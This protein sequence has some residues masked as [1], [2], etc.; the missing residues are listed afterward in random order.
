[1]QRERATGCLVATRRMIDLEDEFERRVLDHLVSARLAAP[2]WQPPPRVRPIDPAA[3]SA[4][5]NTSCTA[6]GDADGG[7]DGA[8]ESSRQMARKRKKHSSNMRA[9]GAGA[10]SKQQSRGER[11]R[12]RQRQS[13]ALSE[14]DERGDGD[15]SASDE[16]A[17]A[18]ASANSSD[19]DSELNPMRYQRRGRGCDSVLSISSS[20]SMS[21]SESDAE[22]SLQQQR[23]SRGET[24]QGGQ[25]Q[26]APVKRRQKR[27]SKS[28]RLSLSESDTEAAVG[29]EAGEGGS[30]GNWRRK[31]LESSCAIHDRMLEMDAKLEHPARLHP[32]LWFNEAAEVSSLVELDAFSFQL[33]AL[34]KY[35]MYFTCEL[36]LR[37][38]YYSCMTRI[39]SVSLPIDERRSGLRLRSSQLHWSDAQ[40]LCGRVVLLAPI[41][42]HMSLLF[43]AFSIPFQSKR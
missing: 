29:E 32:E 15:G 3:A 18:D 17:E 21:M 25:R 40:H 30:R 4:S 37:H 16:E 6:Q 35:C 20:S 41:A 7:G 11:R 26:S 10:S 8:G 23:Q 9:A 42:G 13:A 43:S 2:R 34:F 24:S 38:V 19:T 22:S 31:E 33:L 5:V 36:A 28:K 14:D 27:A 1:M 12:Q 39:H